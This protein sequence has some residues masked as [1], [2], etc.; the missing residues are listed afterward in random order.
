MKS[1]NDLELKNAI[2]TSKEIIIKRK[3]ENI[4]IPLS[5]IKEMEYVKK[6]LLNYILGGGIVAPPGWLRI[7]Y[8]DKNFRRKFYVLKIRYD[9]LLKIPQEILSKIDIT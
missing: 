3:K 7:I 2:Y 5:D 4:I 8:E 1:K 9:D 6:K